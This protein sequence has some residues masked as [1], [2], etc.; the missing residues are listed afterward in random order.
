MAAAA[1]IRR[2]VVC[3][4]PRAPPPSVRH[5]PAG[6]RCRF[7]SAPPESADLKKVL[8]GKDLELQGLRK[9][10]AKLKEEAKQCEKQMHITPAST[11]E[12]QELVKLIRERL[13][14]E[15]QP[16]RQEL[17]AVRAALQDARAEAREATAQLRALQQNAYERH[18]ALGARQLVA[19][20][21]A[22]GQDDCCGIV[23]LIVLYELSTW[24][25]YHNDND[26]F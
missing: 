5:L 25:D 22:Q 11:M 26:S 15:L 23:P 20:A 24:D 12:D 3:C 21:A 19:T 9:E 18:I 1:S 13:A 4:W 10:L 2:R 7:H 14:A 16:L 6:G 17:A 8:D